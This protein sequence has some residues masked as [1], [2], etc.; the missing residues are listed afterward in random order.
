[1]SMEDLLNIHTWL[2]QSAMLDTHQAL[3]HLVAWLDPLQA[4]EDPDAY[5][6]AAYYEGGAEEFLMHAITV[7]RS[8]FPDVYAEL[9]QKLRQGGSEG[10]ANDFIC[11]SIN[12]RIGTE[13]DDIEW[14]TYGIPVPFMGVDVEQD[15]FWEAFPKAALVMGCFGIGPHGSEMQRCGDVQ[16]IVSALI[17]D[18]E[19]R[20]CQDF[21][22]LATLLK[23]LFSGTGSSLMDYTEEYWNDGGMDW[24]RWTP[25]DVEFASE[26]IEEAREMMGSAMRGLELLTVSEWFDAFKI[27]I[28]AVQKEIE[29]R[30][31]G[32]KPTTVPIEWPHRS[33]YSATSTP[34]AES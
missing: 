34:T 12:L 24:L 5:T 31:K 1:M 10:D 29:R 33:D 27:N 21:S 25:N 32:G 13:I 15:D 11:K 6:E 19:A 26:M 20:K 16:T 28:Q 2:A 4:E 22:D 23:W 3:A 30:N 7:C 8:C 14:M 18:F 17:D 9:V